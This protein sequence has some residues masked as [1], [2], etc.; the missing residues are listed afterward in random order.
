MFYIVYLLYLA[1]FLLSSAFVVFQETLFRET[2]VM[3]LC[4]LNQCLIMYIFTVD[5]Y[6]KYVKLFPYALK[7]LF[8]AVIRICKYSVQMRIL[9]SRWF[10]IW[11]GILLW[12]FCGYCIFW[13]SEIKHNYLSRD[14]E[15]ASFQNY[16]NRLKS[17]KNVSLILDVPCRYLFGFSPT[18]NQLISI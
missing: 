15:S 9:G 5:I 4:S 7:T 3:K 10:L 18:W 12:Y 13:H 2:L 14:P 16:K 8:C 11:V 17:C 1:S 6:K